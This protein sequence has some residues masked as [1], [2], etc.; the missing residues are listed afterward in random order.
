[1]QL[2]S[3]A[4]LSFDRFEP[5]DRLEITYF[6]DNEKKGKRERREKK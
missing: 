1:M 3:I 6:H 4:L 5:R 2:S